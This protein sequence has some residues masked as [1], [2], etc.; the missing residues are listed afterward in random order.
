M[1]NVV[2][3]LTKRKL[4]LEKSQILTSQMKYDLQVYLHF[5]GENNRE[6]YTVV[7]SITS[8]RCSTMLNIRQFLNIHFISNLIN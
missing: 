1:Y 8:Q 4:T 6:M 5:Y 7:L 2:F 3:V